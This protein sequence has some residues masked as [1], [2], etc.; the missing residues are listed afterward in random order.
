MAWTKELAVEAVKND[1][2]LAIYWRTS[3][4]NVLMDGM[5]GVNRDALHKARGRQSYR[6]GV[7]PGVCN[8]GL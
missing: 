5:W 3:Q 4:K 6:I 7:F 2:G 8:P 1:Q